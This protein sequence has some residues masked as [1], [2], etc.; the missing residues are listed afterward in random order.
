MFWEKWVEEQL[1]L[2]QG[3]L[4]E[5]STFGSMSSPTRLVLNT[6]DP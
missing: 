5:I 2:G 3:L 6:G 1:W 4:G